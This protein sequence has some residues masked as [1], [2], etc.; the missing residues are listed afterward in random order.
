VDAVR[1]A[2]AEAGIGAAGFRRYAVACGGVAS[3]K[4]LTALGLSEAP[5]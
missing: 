2:L 4:L 1:S 5:S 3:A